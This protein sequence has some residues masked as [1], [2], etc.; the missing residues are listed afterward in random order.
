LS[1]FAGSALSSAMDRSLACRKPDSMD[2]MAS[3]SSSRY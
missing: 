1:F 2:R 3:S